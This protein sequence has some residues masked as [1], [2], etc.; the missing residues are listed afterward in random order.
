MNTKPA[1]PE[2]KP[3]A[4]LR[5]ATARWWCSVV[6]DY[7]LEPHHVRL[8]SLAGEAWDRGQ[9][10]REVIAKEGLTYLDFRKQPKARP[11]ISIER[12]SRLSF[13]RLVRELGLDVADPDQARPPRVGG[14]R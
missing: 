1:K 6:T 14:K 9:Q 12:D 2:P 10:A 3:P 13:A 7:E 8:L 4:H 5:P 11:E